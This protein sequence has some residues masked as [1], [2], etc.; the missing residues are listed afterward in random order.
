[1]SFKKPFRAKPVVLGD[2]ERAKLAGERRNKNRNMVL[3][4]LTIT[5]LV[6]GV[7][8]AIT[9]PVIFKALLPRSGSFFMTSE[10]RDRIERSAYYPSCKV[11]WADDAAPLFRLCF[12]CILLNSLHNP[13]CIPGT[14]D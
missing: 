3:L 14:R 13:T 11:A 9:N 8:M 4:L 6:F 7:G 10:E 5:L 2:F 12:E 1:M